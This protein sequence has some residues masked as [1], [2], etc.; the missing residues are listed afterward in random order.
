M[1]VHCDYVKMSY[2]SHIKIKILAGL[3]LGDFKNFLIPLVL[4]WFSILINSNQ[5]SSF[6]T[7]SSKYLVCNRKKVTGVV[8]A[9]HCTGN[10]SIVNANQIEPLRT[11]ENEWWFNMDLLKKEL[12]SCGNCATKS[13]RPLSGLRTGEEQ[14]SIPFISFRNKRVH[15][16]GDFRG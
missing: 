2:G 3:L 14:F 11:A 15:L 1:T 8:N 7:Y 13:G 16:F 10:A 6:K 9:C 5:L 12:T 4:L